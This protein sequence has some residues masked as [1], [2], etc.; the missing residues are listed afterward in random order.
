[1]VDYHAGGQTA[2]ERYILFMA[3]EDP[4]NPTKIEQIRRK[5]VVAFGLDKAGFFPPGTFGSGAAKTAIEDAGC[6]QITLELGGGTG[7]MK[8]GDEN[9][10][11]AERGAWNVMKAMRMID[12]E[13]EADGPEVTIYNA[14]VVLWKPDVDG[15]FIRK[16]EIGE[17]VKKGEVYATLVDPYTGEHRADILNSQDSTV[18][19][20]GQ[21]WPTIGATSVGILGVVDRV[22]DRTKT[23]IYIDFD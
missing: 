4:N 3:E 16:K 8:N 15:L 6:A 7:W 1:M 2:Y 5:L 23:D 9:V 14:C 17:H 13:I 12:G 10:A 20:S 18:I 19:P 21:N 22:E 11:V